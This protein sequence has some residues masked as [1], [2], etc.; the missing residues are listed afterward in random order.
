MSVQTAPCAGSAEGQIAC[1]ASVV[2]FAD[3]AEFSA[4]A[5]RLLC[6]RAGFRLT[7]ETSMSETA[8]AIIPQLVPLLGCG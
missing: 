6:D 2:H 1:I 5:A 7:D 4:L 3:L 8:L